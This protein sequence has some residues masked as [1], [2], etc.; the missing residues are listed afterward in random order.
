MIVNIKMLNR[1]YINIL[2]IKN[3]GKKKKI[4]IQNNKT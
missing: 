2:M 4:K 1:N 3:K